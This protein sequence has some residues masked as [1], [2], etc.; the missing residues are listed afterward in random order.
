[1]LE[2]TAQGDPWLDTAQVITINESIDNELF[3][4]FILLLR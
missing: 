3:L 2:F 4:F 1:M